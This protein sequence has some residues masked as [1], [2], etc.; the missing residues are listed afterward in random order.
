[1]ADSL[2][3]LVEVMDALRS[4]GG[5]PWDAEQTHE[6]LVRH[7]IEEVYELADAVESGTR[8]ERK[9]NSAMRGMIA[10]SAPVITRV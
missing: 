5:C 7:A 9:R 3:R 4:P 2:A 10:S 8:A 1:M 6:S